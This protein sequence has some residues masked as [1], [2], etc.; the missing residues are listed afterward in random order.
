MPVEAVNVDLRDL[1]PDKQV[2]RLRTE[3]ISLRGKGALVRALVGDLPVRQYVSMLEQGYRV[4]LERGANG[5]C[6]VLHPDG[7]TPRLGLRGAHSVVSHRDG[8]VYTNTTHNR[9]AVVDGSTRQVVRY[10]A[11]GDDPSHLELSHDGRYLYVAN[12]GSD[13]VTIVATRSDLAIATAP[14]GKRPLLP[15]VAPDGQSVYFPSGPERTVTILGTRGEFIRKVP[16]GEAPHDIAVSPDSRWAYQPN[17]ASHTV[18]VIDTRDQSVVGEVKVG[19]GPGHIAFDPESRMAYVA[20][21]LSDDVTVVHTANHDAVATIAAGKGAH[22]PAVSPDGQ[23]GYVANFASDDLTV[24]RTKDY[25]AVARIPVGIYPHFFAISPNGQWIV[26]SNTGESSV[27][28]IDAHTHE[29]R[30]RLAVGGA[31]AHL[32]FD[33]DSESVFVGCESTD[34]VAVIDLER[35]NVLDLIKAGAAKT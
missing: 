29:T 30:A 4:F 7:S 28:V 1:K 31:P 27:C 12:S 16:V 2:D 13:D 15:C 23:Y 33:S 17:S 9:V 32:A 22:L 25:R 8:R 34:E 20:N 10:I 5:Y 14:T 11:V 21:T 3:F 19:L 24:W 6:L 18:S 35:L 26:V